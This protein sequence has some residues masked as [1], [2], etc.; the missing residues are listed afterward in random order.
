[1]RLF[2]KNNGAVSVFLVIILVPV[3]VVTSLFVDVARMHLGQAVV[4]SAG[5][6]ALN[7]AMTQ[8]DSELNEYYG[9][10]GTCKNKD[11]LKKVVR[12]K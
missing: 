10:L 12:N 9:L 6:L 1:M 3:L 5:D 7:T 11:E 2:R 4:D 8:F